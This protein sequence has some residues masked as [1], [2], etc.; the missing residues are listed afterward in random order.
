VYINDLD[1]S[2]VSS[3]QKFADDTQLFGVVD[4]ETPRIMLQQDL[5][6]L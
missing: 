2:L 3:V 6:R 1:S 5:H 4:D